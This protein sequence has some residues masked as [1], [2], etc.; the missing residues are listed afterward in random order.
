MLSL[1][2]GCIRGRSCEFLFSVFFDS[3]R[4]MVTLPMSDSNAGCQKAPRGDFLGN[5]QTRQFSHSSLVGLVGLV[6]LV[7][8]SL[9]SLIWSS[10]SGFSL[11]SLVRLVSLVILD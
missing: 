2:R 5:T 9:I 10:Q 4:K 7:S 6:S 11:V 1:I 8:L 3:R